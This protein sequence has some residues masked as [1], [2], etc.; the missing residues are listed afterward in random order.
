MD[1]LGSSSST[2]LLKQVPC[3]KSQRWVPRWILNISTEDSTTCLDSLFQISLEHHTEALPVKKFLCIV[4]WNFLYSIFSHWTL[5]HQNWTQKSKCGLT[6]AEQRGMI[7]LLTL[8][9][10][11]S[12]LLRTPGWG[13]S[14]GW[15]LLLG[16]DQ[17]GFSK[18]GCFIALD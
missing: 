12:W 8:L 17:P 5:S 16:M 18:N 13:G 14:V 3:S 11:W 6:R 2:P 10:T 4:V 7:T 9:A 15:D 1:L